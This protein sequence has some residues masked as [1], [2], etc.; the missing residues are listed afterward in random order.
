MNAKL[1]RF[2]VLIIVVASIGFLAAR[3]AL[4]RVVWLKL[5]QPSVAISLVR[6][7]VALAMLMGNYYFNGTI[8]ASVYEP[9]IAER[10]FRKAVA[11]NPNILWGHY[12]LARVLFTQGRHDEALHEINAELKANPGNLRSLYVRGLIFGYQGNLVNAENDFRRFVEWSPMEWAGYNDLAWILS[13]QRKYAEA[14]E[15][16]RAAL[17]KVPDADNNPWLWNSLGVAYLNQAKYQQA[18][19]AFTKAGDLASKLSPSEWSRAYPGNNPTSAESGLTVF[20]N[21]IAENLQRAHTANFSD[22]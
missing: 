20:R 6:K 14:E 12:Q 2:L 9:D 11:I 8:G 13:K 16:I 5:H 4:A 15:T 1:L 3:D 7:D 21:A 10:A 17:E 19:D 18:L 22:N